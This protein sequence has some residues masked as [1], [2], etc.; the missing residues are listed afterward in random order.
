MSEH[1]EAPKDKTA[2]P[3]VKKPLTQE[4]KILQYVLIALFAGIIIFLLAMALS[5][6]VS[7]W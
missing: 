6:W 2:I 1:Q 3:P 4:Q 7:P 5:Q